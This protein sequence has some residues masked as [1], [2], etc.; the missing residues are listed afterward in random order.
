[1]STIDGGVYCLAC[2]LCKSAV[3]FDQV[4][5]DEEPVQFGQCPQCE[6]SWYADDWVEAESSACVE[7]AALDRVPVD[8]GVEVH[9]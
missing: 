6:G 4:V 2:P 3:P 9:S 5:W 7:S 1:M 8:S